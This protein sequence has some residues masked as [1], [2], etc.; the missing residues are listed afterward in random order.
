MAQGFTFDASFAGIRIDVL[1]ANVRHGRKGKLHTFA[2]RNG[3][4]KEDSGREPWVCDMEFIFVDRKAQPGETEA[5]GTA[6][7]RWQEFDSL[8]DEGVVRRLVHPYVGAVLCSLS[9]YT[10]AADG[11]GGIEISCS[12]TFTEENSLPPTFAA[13]V[14]VQTIA[15]AHE[16]SSKALQASGALELSGA[17]LS[18]DELTDSQAEIDAA[19]SAV[20]E[21]DADP[22]VTARQVHLQMASIIN[23]LSARLDALNAAT[24]IDRYPIMKQYTLLQY[25]VRLAAEAF[26][27]DT[28]RIVTITTKQPLPLRVIAG[29][30]YGAAE[31]DRRFAEMLELNPEIRNPALIARGIELKAY[32]ANAE[33]GA[34]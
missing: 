11:D 32:A 5:P 21:W 31:A 17:A 15:G 26:T 6:L 2:K 25:Q 34:F 7:E 24:N 14:G 23:A 8:V 20:E 4:T 28:T 12:A 3:G 13:G 10:H 18:G 16:V 1:S 19:V 30:F 33:P 27:T 9:D 22:T 29:R